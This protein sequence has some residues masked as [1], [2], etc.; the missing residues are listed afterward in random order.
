MWG[1]RELSIQNLPAPFGKM[2]NSLGMTAREYNK[3]YEVDNVRISDILQEYGGSYGE[4]VY[5]A[6]KRDEE[7]YYVADVP[8]LKGM[9][10]AG[11][12]S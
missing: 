9:P 2:L 8:E 7:G 3:D 6:Y 11:T 4:A 5:R 12:L 1:G 10:H